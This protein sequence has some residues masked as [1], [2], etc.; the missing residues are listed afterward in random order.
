MQSRREARQGRKRAQQRQSQMRW[1]A[2]IS[3]AAV[4]VAGVLIISSQVRAPN[5]EHSYTDKKGNQLGDPDAPVLIVEYADFQCTH[6]RNFFATTESLLIENHVESGEVFFEYHLVDFLGPE[7]ALSAEAAYCAADQNMF[8][9]YHD[10]VFSNFSTGNTGGYSEK[11]LIDFAESLDMDIAR[12]TDCLRSGEK[13]EQV[14]E[15]EA[16]AAAQGVTG[17]PSF[18]IN[19]L[20]LEGNQPYA[21]LQEAIEAALAA[22]R[23]D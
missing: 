14:A 19:G 21:A 10:V 12:F 20:V 13:A 8:W 11:R 17:T 6:C 4:V 16:L 5:T 23:S 3:I 7:S 1:L 22:H 18:V 15:S 2:F 9:E